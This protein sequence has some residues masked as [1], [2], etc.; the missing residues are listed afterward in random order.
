MDP[1]PAGRGLQA[2]QCLPHRGIR[3]DGDPLTLHAPLAS[4]NARELARTRFAPLDRTGPQ[5][6][7]ILLDTL[8]TWLTL[9]GQP[10][11]GLW[12]ALQ[13]HPEG[14]SGQRTST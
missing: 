3:D 6:A 8:R 5:G 11:I 9:H 1:P 14:R 12:F 7:V 13:L 4:A 10:R 2:G